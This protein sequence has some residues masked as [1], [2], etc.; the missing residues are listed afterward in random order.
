MSNQGGRGGLLHPQSRQFQLEVRDDSGFAGLAQELRLLGPGDESLTELRVR[1]VLVLPHHAPPSAQALVLLSEHDVTPVKRTRVDMPPTARGILLEEWSITLDR[2]RDFTL[3]TDDPYPGIY[4]QAIAL[5]RSLFALLRYLP[6]WQL[7]RKIGAMQITVGTSTGSE[8]LDEGILGFDHQLVPDEPTPTS[9]SFPPIATPL[10]SITLRVNY[11]PRVRFRLDPL[12]NLL[13]SQFASGPPSPG[14]QAAIQRIGIGST[15]PASP[16]PPAP[17]V[18]PDQLAFTPTLLANR[19]RASLTGSGSPLRPSSTR[20]STTPTLGVGPGVPAIRPR[21]VSQLSS[22]GE[23]SSPRRTVYDLLQKSPPPSPRLGTIE[24]GVATG[25]SGLSRTRTQ[26]LLSAGVRS[27]SSTPFGATGGTG[28]S[29]VLGGAAGDNPPASPARRTSSGIN[30]F[31]SPTLGSSPRTL[32]TNSPRTTPGLGIGTPPRS[33]L[34]VGTTGGSDGRKSLDSADRGSDVAGP[35]ASGAQP[36]PIKRYESSFGHRRGHGS[37]GSG[38]GVG[39]VGSVGVPSS[40]G[41]PGSLGAGGSGGAASVGGGSVGSGGTGEPHRRLTTI[42]S[43]SYESHLAEDEDL[44]Q[45]I[46]DIDRRPQLGLDV[47]GAAS[48][49]GTG[50]T[51]RFPLSSPVQERLPLGSPRPGP[52][53]LT[54]SPRPNILPL[55]GSNAPLT[56]SPRPT[57]FPLSNSPRAGPLPLGGSPRH[58]RLPS[59]DSEPARAERFPPSSLPARYSA[60]PDVS[61]SPLSP[62]APRPLPPALQSIPPSPAESAWPSRIRERSQSRERSS[63]SRTRGFGEPALAPL[64]E[65]DLGERVRTLSL[66]DRPAVLGLRERTTSL[67]PSTHER[68]RTSSFARINRTVLTNLDDVEAALQLYTAEFNASYA[69]PS[70]SGAGTPLVESGRRQIGNDEI[71]G[72]LELGGSG[73]V[74]GSA[75]GSMRPG[76][77]TDTWR[78]GG[79]WD[80]RMGGWR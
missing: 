51:E 32:G 41:R 4:K 60:L 21:T 12:E 5:I 50:G 18:N 11:R 54:S 71:V 40:F 39:G 14:S 46:A 52:L 74:G 73:S 67:T 38:S 70:P 35:T 55:G 47:S 27:G 7:H 77:D 79:E 42:G 44:G 45:F 58:R 78:E 17:P 62:D 76:R 25:A 68:Q 49:E 28:A 6:T 59:V 72:R 36:Q 64:P 9:F 53:P 56:S 65:G 30:A 80:Q 75:R 3:Q 63:A 69:P 1:T 8:P 61:R 29:L 66:A 19:Q 20:P 43:Q 37:V 10:G 15:S 48:T 13:S 24:A 2:A 33:G 31:K 23:P 57:P 16:S 26:S 34:S 22:G